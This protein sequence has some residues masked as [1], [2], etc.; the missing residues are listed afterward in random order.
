MNINYNYYE[1]EKVRKVHGTYILLS[2]MYNGTTYNDSLYPTR[3]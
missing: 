1:I 2:F 3:T